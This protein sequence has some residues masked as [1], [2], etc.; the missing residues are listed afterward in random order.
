[1]D[2]IIDKL[3]LWFHS[4][5]LLLNAQKSKL[6]LVT[7][8]SVPELPVIRFGN[9]EIEWVKSI[10]YLGLTIDNKLNF[11]N[12]IQDVCNQLSKYNGIIYSLSKFVPRFILINI[13]YSLV[14]PQIIQNIVIWGG[15]NKTNQQRIT[16]ALNKI[17]RNIL[18]VRFDGNGIP[19]I[20][21][22][23]MYKELN[24]LKFEDIHIY[25]TL[26]FIHFILYK[27]FDVFERCFAHLLPLNNYNMRTKLINLPYI[28]TEAERHSTLYQVC[29][30]I[31]GLPTHFLD[32]VSDHTLKRKF[33]EYAI[34]K[35]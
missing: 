9:V 5:K 16:V 1:M 7:P 23:S 30:V 15:T 3:K 28:R 10:K 25:F 20:P 32:Q 22:N 31:R 12:H 29:E 24:F 35:Y 21:V 6:M 18:Q 14:Y 4:N 13:Y 33:K 19:I 27:R 17:L 26:K 2:T 11:N 8:K 34:S